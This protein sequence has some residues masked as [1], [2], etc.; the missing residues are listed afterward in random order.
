MPADRKQKTISDRNREPRKSSA[1]D[2]THLDRRYGRIGIEAVAA[3][4]QFRPAGDVAAKD[5]AQESVRIE[6]RFIEIAA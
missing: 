2:S 6:E 1:Q 3:A 4:L 5:T